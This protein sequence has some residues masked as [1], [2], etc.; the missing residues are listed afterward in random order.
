MSLMID[1]TL[2]VPETPFP[3]LGTHYATRWEQ[4]DPKA[5]LYVEPTIEDALMLAREIA[6]EKKGLDVLVTGSLHLVGGALS[7]LRPGYHNEL[8]L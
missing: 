3:N 5:Q 8:C 1:K 4:L 6:V 7:L 2:K